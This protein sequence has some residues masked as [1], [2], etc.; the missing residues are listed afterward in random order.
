MAFEINTGILPVTGDSLLGES[1]LSDEALG[2][3]GTP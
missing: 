3:A 2:R 1:L